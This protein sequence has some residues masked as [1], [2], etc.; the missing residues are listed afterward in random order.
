[1]VFHT[2]GEP[3]KPVVLLLHGA[4]LSYWGYEAAAIRLA[5]EYRVVLPTL[6]A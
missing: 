4:G 2:Y 6:S 5:A 3:G 1:M